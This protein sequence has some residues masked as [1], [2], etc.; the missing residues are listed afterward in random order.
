MQG[1]YIFENHVTT[2]AG[3]KISNISYN[4]LHNRLNFKLYPSGSLTLAL[5]LRNRM[6]SGQLLKQIPTYATSISTDNGLI[7]L[8]WNWT[9]QDNYL[10]NTVIDRAYIDYTMGNWQLRAGRHRIN[11]GIN[12]VWNPNDI[13]NAF[14]YMDFD[15]EERP[16]S[17]AILVTWYPTMSSSVDV[18]YK[19]AS[20]IENS[21]LAVKYRFNKFNYDFQ[22]LAGQSGVDYVLGGGWSGN[23]QN[24]GFRGEASYFK[25]INNYKS[26]SEEGVS[27]SVSLDYN[28][29]NSLYVHTSF[30]FNSLG[31]TEK[32][33]SFS[34]IDPNIQ[35]SAK[36]LSIGKYEWFGQV[37][38]PIGTLFNV[39]GAAMI[40]PVDLSMFIGPSVSVSLQ[41]NLELF[42]T[43]QLMLGESGT[44]YAAMGNLYALFGRLRWSF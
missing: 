21:A 20:S 30:L 18:A 40:N 24:I 28:F 25:P 9:K 44:E 15:Y 11:W 4:L 38:Y 33:E 7:D 3:N 1:I 31:S 8:S 34:L 43:S 41:N 12:F 42:L 14:S 29:E 26:Q 23:I 13:F 35:L 19:A 6:F 37:S 27:V 10:I 2:S 32:G 36:K 16:G 5:E 22:I 39:S 17:D